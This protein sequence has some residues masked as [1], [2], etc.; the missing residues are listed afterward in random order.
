MYQDHGTDNARCPNAVTTFSTS[1]Q[2]H[3][4]G[5]PGRPAPAGSKH[6]RGVTE[7]ERWTGERSRRRRPDG[8]GNL[9][10]GGRQPGPLPLARQRTGAGRCRSAVS[11]APAA[12]GPR[13]HAP[14]VT[15]PARAAGRV[16][17]RRASCRRESSQ[18]RALRP[19]AYAA[20][21]S[22]AQT[23]DWEL[24][25]Q[26][27]APIGRTRGECRDPLLERQ[28]RCTAVGRVNSGSPRTST[29][30]AQPGHAQRA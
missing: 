15:A 7:G 11:P 16:L 25:R 14:P 24:P 19:A 2:G 23:L 6:G 5:A 4:F 18:P 8:T 29:A 22:Q 13:R 1:L 21:A 12:G 9:A 28:A 3:A 30:V 17:P 20:L 27:P 10:A 26:E